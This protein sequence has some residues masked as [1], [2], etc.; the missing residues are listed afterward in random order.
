METFLKDISYG[1]RT[2]IKKPGFTAVA[3]VALAL[4]I[5]ANSSIFSVVNAVLL[6]PLPFKNPD[7]LVI[8]NETVRR[9]TVETR[10]ASYPD[11][12]DWRNQNQSFEDIA[13]FDSPT[14]SLTG[15][16]EPERIPGEI[17]SASYFPILG[18]QP[19]VG[20]TFLPEEDSTPDRSPVAVISYK[21]WQRRFGS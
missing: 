19:A 12:I 7:Q 11:F 6:R 3:V 15:T 9:E 5:G 17:V 10:P 20:R 8:I 21:L 14:F 18:I 1:I 2:M 4:G 13:A 16:N